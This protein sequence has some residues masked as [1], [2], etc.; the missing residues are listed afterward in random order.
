MR[1]YSELI[2][3]PTFKERFEYLS[4]NGRVGRE[5]FGVD[6]WIN[7]G[8]YQ[9]ARW[10]RL[11]QKI[12]LRDGACDLAHPDHPL[13]EGDGIYIHHL[14]PITEDD[15]LDDTE[16]LTNPEFLV[17]TSYN[18]HNAIHYGDVRLLPSS[19]VERTPWDTAPWRVN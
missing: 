5:T 13:D 14:N 8:F 18:T 12:I 17:V 19:F 11:R 2:S 6:R 15:I 4:L 1:T 9:S 7:Q 16:Y 10:R 3:L